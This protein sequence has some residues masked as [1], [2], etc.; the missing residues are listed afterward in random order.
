MLP[1]L[2]FSIFLFLNHG[3]AQNFRIAE[4]EMQMINGLDNI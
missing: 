3:N 1:F 2:F 4:I